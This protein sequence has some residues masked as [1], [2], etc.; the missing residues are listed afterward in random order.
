M[1]SSMELRMNGVMQIANIPVEPLI[2]CT[3]LS[4]I[5]RLLATSMC[6][7][8]RIDYGTCGS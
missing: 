4:S 1:M 8:P 3:D 7:I 2:V 6:Q 5:H